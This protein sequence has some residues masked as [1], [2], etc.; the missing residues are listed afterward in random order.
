MHRYE[1]VCT[2]AVAALGLSACASTAPTA[3]VAPVKRPAFI[4]ASLITRDVPAYLAAHFAPRQ[5]PPGVRAKIAQA[6]PV[7]LPFHTLVVT[8][9]FVRHVTRRDVT[10]KI[11]VTDRLTN[12]GS[13]YVQGRE[14]L[15]FNTIPVAL[16][17][18][19]SYAGFMSL[20]HQS[21]D[22]RTGRAGPPLRLRQ[23]LALTPG[24]AHPE[25]GK[26]YRLTLRWLSGRI[27]DTCKAAPRF[28]PA[29]RL[30]AQ[31][32]GRALDLNCAISRNGVVRSRNRTT[33]LSAYGIFL[34]ME[35]RTAAFTARGQLLSL[36]A[37]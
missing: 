8:R 24:V 29:R 14:Q 1:A 7:T 21:V 31:L 32:P 4:R 16:N 23:L 13:G 3:A 17:L 15:S 11:L 6:G 12:I 34:I 10:V 30:L 26:T 25:P 37:D 36:K 19:L 22:Y 5:L 28:Y 27:T 35:R 33:Y 2:A 18:N 20:E 9:Q